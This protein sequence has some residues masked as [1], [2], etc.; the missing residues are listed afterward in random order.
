MKTIGLFYGSLTGY[1]ESVADEIASKLGNIKVGLH[2]VAH[3]HADAMTAYDYLI[4]GTPTWGDGELQKDWESYVRHFDSAGLSSKTVAL[5]GLG[6]QAHFGDRF[7]NAMGTLYDKVVSCGATVV[8]GWPTDGY[9]FNDST[10]VRNGEFVGLA[11]DEANQ[12]DLTSERIARWIELIA[13]YFMG[14]AA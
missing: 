9:A 5:F 13:P 2:D 12:P 3:C 14:K 1:T 8:G 11:L 4:M 6:D 7:L 10:A